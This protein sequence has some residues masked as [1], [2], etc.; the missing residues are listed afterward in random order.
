MHY[1]Q[2]LLLNDQDRIALLSSHSQRKTAEERQ[3]NRHAQNRITNQRHLRAIERILNERP[4]P[5]AHI[6]YTPI[7]GQP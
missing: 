4:R 1:Q 2:Y 5:Q 3:V 6:I 7:G